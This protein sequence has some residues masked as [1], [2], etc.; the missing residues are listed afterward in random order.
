MNLLFA[1]DLAWPDTDIIDLSALGDLT[2][3]GPLLVNLEGGI[4][5]GPAEQSAVANEYKF[6]LFS[7]ASVVDVL[8][9]LNVV[10]CGLANNHVSD[11]VGA[12]DISKTLLAQQDIAVCGTR[13]VPWCEFTVGD[14]QFVVFAAC[15]RLPEPRVDSTADHAL[16][17]EPAAALATLRSLR[18]RFPQATLVAFMHWGYE[19]AR[20][21]QPADREWAREAVDAGVNLVIGHHPHIVQGVEQYKAGVIAYSLGNF[22]LPQVP[23]RGRKLH[24]KTP[25]VCEQLILEAAPS[26]LRAHWL[27][28]DPASQT[29][30]YDHSGPV[31]DDDRIRQRTPFA[32]MTDSEY[33]SWFSKE[34]RFGTEGKLPGTVFWGYRGWRGAESTLKLAYLSAR[35]SVRKLAISTGVHKPY[36][37]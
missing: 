25:A 11:Y 7:H 26:G 24:Y 31:L 18:A 2:A 33:R 29:V 37:W 27:Q 35:R 1:G 14:T 21:P 9:R 12:V 13:D 34:G 32:G 23:Y 17:F 10:A 30:T 20:Y 4:I 19:L 8:K 22:L 3:H 36:N 28:Y 5:D 6:N 16:I 15:S